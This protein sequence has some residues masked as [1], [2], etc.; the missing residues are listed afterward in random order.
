MT[1]LVSWWQFTKERFEPASHLLMIAFF[2]AVHQM[3]ASVL[4][5][6]PLSSGR[7]LATGLLA[8]LFFFKL[9]LYDEIKD[10]EVDLEF[11]PTRPLARGLL[12]V[13]QVKKAIVLVLAIELLILPFLG[14]GALMVGTVAIAYSLLMFREFFIG[15]L[16]RPHLTTYAVTHTFVSSLLSATLLTALSGTSPA[17]WTRG[18]WAFVLASWFLFNIFEFGRKTFATQEERG[19]VESYSKI[20][21]RSGAVTL[22]MIQAGIASWLYV[23]AFPKYLNVAGLALAGAALFLTGVLYS[24]KDDATW[25][26]AYRAL[27]SG[28]IVLVFSVALAASF[29]NW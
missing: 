1:L 8:V 11:N 27:S 6:A 26:K 19:R 24:F 28:Y 9:R 14:Q 18:A 25:A 20:F 15:P 10:Y 17:N 16:L 2:V 22:V 29:F 23:L 12:S 21:G 13:A 4:L 5:W 3:A 7:I